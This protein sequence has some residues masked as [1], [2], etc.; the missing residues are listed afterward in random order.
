MK[1]KAQG[2]SMN[3][4]IIAAISLLVLVIISVLVLRAGGNVNES[5]GCQGVGGVCAGGTSSYANC[6][7]VGQTLGGNY[8][9]NPSHGCQDDTQ[10]CCIPLGNNQ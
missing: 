3:V 6:N 9:R 1:T 10:Y 7:D 8:I 5:T 2:L 4:I